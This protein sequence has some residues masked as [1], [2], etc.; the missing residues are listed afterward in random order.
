MSKWKKLSSKIILKHQFLTVAEDTVQLASGKIINDYLTFV[1]L[2]SYVTIIGLSSDA[3]ILTIKEHTYP[4]NQRILQFPEG[5]ID[6]DESIIECAKRELLEETGYS[7]EKFI[8]IGRSL[9]AHRRSTRLQ[10]V[11]LAKNCYKVSNPDLKGLEEDL[12]VALYQPNDINKLISE[13]KIIQQNFLSA[14]AIYLNK[15]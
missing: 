14:W 1:D 10:Y 8:E 3:K 6:S 15:K 4:L 7:A 2:K 12:S 11:V 5:D 9:P 13:G